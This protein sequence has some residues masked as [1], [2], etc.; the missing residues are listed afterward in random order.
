MNRIRVLFCGSHLSGAEVLRDLLDTPDEFEVTGVWTSKDPEVRPESYASV[1]D[2]ARANEIPVLVGNPRNDVRFLRHLEGLD[3]IVCANYRYILPENIFRRVARGA[4]NIHGS[5]LPA[6]RGRTP[7]TWAIIKG[8]EQTGAT[9]HLIEPQVDTGPILAQER[10]QIDPRDTGHTLFLRMVELYPK[11]VRRGI[12]NLLDPEFTPVK[13]DES[14]ASEYPARRPEDGRI[15][16]SWSARE[17]YDWIRAQTDPYPG[18]FTFFQG[19]RVRVWNGILT[20][21]VGPEQSGPPGKIVGIALSPDVSGIWVAAGDR[22][23]LLTSVQIADQ[24]V[25]S[26]DSLLNQLWRVGDILGT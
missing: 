17:V 2:I 12:Y 13:Q 8:E 16:W 6:Y 14:Q 15:E 9:V 20:D 4:I 18:A 1:L 5:F 10:V 24:G 23:I 11:L 3:V 22:P 25:C 26:P 19:Q 7:N 21:V